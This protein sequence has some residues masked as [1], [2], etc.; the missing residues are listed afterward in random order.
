MFENRV[1]SRIFGRK[2]KELKVGCS[3]LQYMEF[4]NLKILVRKT[5]MPDFGK[6]YSP[7]PQKKTPMDKGI[8]KNYLTYSADGPG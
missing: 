8:L 7:P 6:T 3:K 1:Q 4:R 5:R 2:R